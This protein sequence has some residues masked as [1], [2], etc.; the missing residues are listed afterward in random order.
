MRRAILVAKSIGRA[1]LVSVQPCA[2]CSEGYKESERCIGIVPHEREV[3]AD[4]LRKRNTA[5]QQ[6][7][8]RRGKSVPDVLS[9][10]GKTTKVKSN[11]SQKVLRIVPALLSKLTWVKTT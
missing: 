11:N 7:V 2:I 1:A 4:M 10:W 8:H 3:A 9:Q 6:G 5:C